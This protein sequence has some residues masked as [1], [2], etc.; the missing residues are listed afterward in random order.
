MLLRW[1][2]VTAAR[3]LPLMALTRWCRNA[4]ARALNTLRASG[5]AR[6]ACQRA[7]HRTLNHRLAAAMRTWRGAAAAVVAQHERAYA[8]L[9]HWWQ[10]SLSAAWNSWVASAAAAAHARQLLARVCLVWAGSVQLQVLLAWRGVLDEVDASAA[11]A[12]RYATP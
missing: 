1:R 3:S 8:A 9:A 5:A 12:G 7:L 4:E 6:A 11:E 10:G 2:A